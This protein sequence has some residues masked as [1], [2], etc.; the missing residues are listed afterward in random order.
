MQWEALSQRY[1]VEWLWAAERQA[2]PWLRQLAVFPPGVP[3]LDKTEGAVG[4][5]NGRER[6]LSVPCV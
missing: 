6:L 1:P 5:R 3:C 2:Q 4:R